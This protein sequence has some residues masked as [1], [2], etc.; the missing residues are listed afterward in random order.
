[1]NELLDSLLNDPNQYLNF[2]WLTSNQKMF[3]YTIVLTAYFKWLRIFKYIRF[4]KTMSQFV[5]TLGNCAKD[6]FGFTFMFMIIFVAYAIFGNL[7]FGHNCP[8]Y[9][10]FFET[11][12][13]FVK[14]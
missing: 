2:E 4:N 13:V 3:D 12:F 14:F 5:T 8:D 11:M 7:M 6:M 10:S 9:Y 1:M